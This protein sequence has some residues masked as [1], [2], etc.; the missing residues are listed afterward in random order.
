[1]N[2][3]VAAAL[4][5]ALPARA[6]VQSALDR[7]QGFP[8]GLSLP[9]SGAAAAEGPT[10]LGVNPAGVGFGVI[11]G[12]M[13][14]GNGLGGAIGPWLGGVVHDVTGSYRIVPGVRCLLCPGVRV[15]LARRRR[16]P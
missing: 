14:I 12:A 5:A 11:Y 6:Q 2:A 9:V 8:A 4:A 3:A 16:A 10:A 7:D 1:M 13:S 15:L